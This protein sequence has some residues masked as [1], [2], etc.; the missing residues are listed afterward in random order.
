MERR[1]GALM[2]ARARESPN[3]AKALSRGRRRRHCSSEP[4]C[5]TAAERA[6]AAVAGI[7]AHDARG[8]LVVDRARRAPRSGQSCATERVACDRA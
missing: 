2:G 7:A 4:I 8:W 1:T 5:S 6:P 3:K